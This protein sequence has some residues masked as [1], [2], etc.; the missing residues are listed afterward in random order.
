MC[1][2][3]AKP[4]RNC[5]TALALHFWTT[6]RTKRSFWRL[7]AS[8]LDEVSYE[9][10]VLETCRTSLL[11]EVSDETLVLETWRFTFGRSLVRSARFGDL[12]LH[13]WTKSRTK[14][15]FWRL[16]ALHFWRESRTKRSFW[17]LGASLLE[18]VSDETLVLETWRFTF[19]RSLVRSARFGDLALHFWTKSRTKRSF[20]RLGASLLD[21]VS[22]EVLVLETCRTSLLE[23]VS[24]E[25]LV[26][27]TWRFTFGGSL[28][29]NTGFG[30]LTLHFWTKSRTK[31]SFWRLGASLLGE[32]SYEALVLET[33]RFTFGRSL[34]RSARFGDLS[35]FTFGGSL[36]RNTRFGDLALHF[37]GKSRTTRSFW[38]LGASL[39]EEVSYETFL[40]ETWHFTFG[41]SLGRNARFGDLA[42][43][44]W[45]KSWTKRSFWRLGASLV[46]LDSDQFGQM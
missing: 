15:S 10:L 43:H 20:W 14:C 30:D 39:L 11:E 37:R 9:V 23:G 7:G 8:L 31:R 24:D 1:V 34:V 32:A 35:H 5:E 13:F 36:G 6:S 38:R 12:A 4:R 42:L 2:G 3:W 29:R 21:E 26:L 22:Y 45:R 40:L 18:E 16:V 27:E 17:R 33:W 28:G 46:E 19:G 25:T 44:F 41:G